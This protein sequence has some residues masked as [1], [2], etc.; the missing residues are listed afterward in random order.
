MFI[1]I[2]FPL[3]VFFY[4]HLFIVHWCIVYYDSFHQYKQIYSWSI[5]CDY[6]SMSLYVDWYVRKCV[7]HWNKVRYNFDNNKK[8]QN[9]LFVLTINRH[10]DFHQINYF[11]EV[12]LRNR[13]Q[14]LIKC[15][16]NYILF[17]PG[18]IILY[19]IFFS[20]NTLWL[21]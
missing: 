1:N 14:H 9:I 5:L 7:Y 15:R 18:S 16:L 6:N 3:E 2:F 11:Y 10:C 21:I 8:K 4:G 19:Y 20:F 12:K 13:M 17:W